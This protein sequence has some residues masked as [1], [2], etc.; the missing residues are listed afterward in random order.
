VGIWT[1]N[2]LFL[3]LHL[4]KWQLPSHTLTFLAKTAL[5]SHLNQQETKPVEK[6]A[7][8]DLSHVEDA[9]QSLA[10]PLKPP[11]KQSKDAQSLRAY[12]G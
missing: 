11:S 10:A 3:S 6:F 2:Y 12:V 9:E 8:W 7:C 5:L 4:G 1:P